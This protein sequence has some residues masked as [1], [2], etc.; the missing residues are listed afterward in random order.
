[1]PTELVKRKLTD[2][3]QPQSGKIPL[4][5]RR[6]IAALCFLALFTL[7]LLAHF[8]QPHGAEDVIDTKAASSNFDN[9]PSGTM[10]LVAIE[11]SVRWPLAKLRETGSNNYNLLESSAIIELGTRSHIANAFAKN[12]YNF[13]WLAC[14]MIFVMAGISVKRTLD[15]RKQ[16]YP[17]MIGPAQPI[18][19]AILLLAGITFYPGAVICYGD[20]PREEI[21]AIVADSSSD[22]AAKTAARNREL[23]EYVVGWDKDAD[24]ATRDA[25]TDM[26]LAGQPI[27][28]EVAARYVQ[29]S[30]KTSSVKGDMTAWSAFAFVKIQNTSEWLFF[31]GARAFRDLWLVVCAGLLFAILLLALWRKPPARFLF[32]AFFGCGAVALPGMAICNAL[33]LLV[34]WIGVVL[35]FTMAAWFIGAFC[36]LLVD[37]VALTL[38]SFFVHYAIKLVMFCGR[39]SISI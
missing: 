15:R 28:A 7:V 8:M 13:A 22:L 25:T 10:V 3:N 27:D 12:S 14:I 36:L 16:G 11:G 29:Y 32:G 1:M 24:E 17:D 33:F 34:A 31:Q 37:F 26:I 18:V 35:P 19:L 5:N 23:V 2:F 20:L 39:K 9:R 6:S 38:A 30:Q 4:L 21:T